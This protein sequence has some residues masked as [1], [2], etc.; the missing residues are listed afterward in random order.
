MVADLQTQQNLFQRRREL[1][2][3]EQERRG[4]VGEGIDDVGTIGEREPVMKRDVRTGFHLG[5]IDDAHEY[6]M[7]PFSRRRRAPRM[8]RGCRRRARRTARRRCEPCAKAAI[9]SHRAVS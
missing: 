9:V 5:D 2:R 3:T 1:A 6:W 7:W 4:L 8:R